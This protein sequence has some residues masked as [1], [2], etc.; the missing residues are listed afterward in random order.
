MENEPPRPES[1]TPIRPSR[2]GVRGLLIALVV[3]TVLPILGSALLS[4]RERSA[5]AREEAQGRAL[6]N[7]REVAD[8]IDARARHIRGVLAATAR[9]V[10][11]S[12]ADTLRN[13][14]L[15]LDIRREATS[16]LVTNLWVMTPDGANIGTSRR[17]VGD[18]ALLHAAGRL[19]LREAVRTRRP[20][21]GEP[22]RSRPDSTLWS[23][24]FAHPVLDEVGE[25]AAVVIGTVNLGTLGPSLV[26]RDLPDG[27]FLT[28]MD[29]QGRVLARSVDAERW[30]GRNISEHQHVAERLRRATGVGE[31]VALDGVRRL[32]GYT[33]A[34]EVPW[35]AVAAIPTTAAYATARGELRRD[36]ALATA[37]LIVAL[38]AAI[39]IAGRL[40]RPLR[41]LGHDARALAGGDVSPPV[42]RRARSGGVRELAALGEAFDQMA[43]TVAARTAQLEESERR[44]RELFDRSPLPI[45]VADLESY[46]LL[47]VNDA[48]IAQYGYARDEFLALSLTDIRPES[49]RLRFLMAA[50][51]AT[52][53]HM[54]GEPHTAGVWPHQRKDGTL[55]EVQTFSIVTEYDGRAAFITTCI[56]VTARRRT[57]R[58][59]AESQERLR[60]AQKME[61]LGRFAGG[62]SHDFNNLLTGILGYCELALDALPPGE[63]ARE[64]VEE[65]RNTAHRAADLTRQI[66][67]FSGR[68]VRQPTTLDINE[69]VR[70]LAGVIERVVGERVHVVLALQPELDTVLA[71]RTQIE[72]VLMNLVV[73]ARDAMPDGGTLTIATE[74]VQDDA[75]PVMPRAWVRLSVSDTGTGMDE[76]IQA[77]IFEPFFTTKPRG[78]GTGLGLATV[79]G[80]VQQSG[81][82]LRVRSARG[83]GS[84]FEI[85]LPRG[86]HHLMDAPA[87]PALAS[88]PAE[89]GDETLLVVDDDDAVRTLA[90]SVLGRLGYAVLV[91]RSAEEAISISERYDAVIHLLVTDV[92]M[93]GL[94]GRELAERLARDRPAMRALLMSGYTEDEPLH[95]AVSSRGM[96]FLAKPF[97]PDTLARRVRETLDEASGRELHAPQGHLTRGGPVG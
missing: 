58:A 92:V 86:E 10:G 1:I 32:A 61:A 56:D 59:L 54:R 30:V 16:D 53:M 68:Q 51:A 24:H 94:N 95:A 50:R 72:Q 39:A 41:A 85:T 69:V 48:A 2:I 64:D 77:Q 27:S 14:S 44:H 7:A 80:I 55:I 37:A 31:I 42:A 71:D 43:R 4:V 46:R 25:V 76:G 20:T 18:R 28:L 70:D 90:R 11:T 60:N 93:P 91:A 47:A 62:I 40:T 74:D 97:T 22:V 73:N 82:R 52:E 75:D 57:E 81:G 67:A 15:L 35:T 89:G 29:Q 26:L 84:T 3:A 65:I 17:P 8:R 23:V 34:T 79:D 12:P 83:A 45:L 38:V 5:R 49:D 19:Y 78:K 36:L 33:R 21:L 9:A 88:A 87:V 6:A 96:V 13:D 66:L 63:P